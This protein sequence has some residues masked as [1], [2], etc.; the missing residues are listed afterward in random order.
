[1]EPHGSLVNTDWPRSCLCHPLCTN[2]L[3]EV[4]RPAA[5]SC[6]PRKSTFRKSKAE[7]NKVTLERNDAEG[8]EL[9]KT[10]ELNLL[11]LNT[12]LDHCSAL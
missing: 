10:L 12:T 8:L 1:M 3:S 9:S 2:P 5:T 4:G 7:V 6:A 11:E